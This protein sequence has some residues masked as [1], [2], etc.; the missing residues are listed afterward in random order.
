MTLDEIKDRIFELEKA[1]ETHCPATFGLE[2]AFLLEFVEHVANAGEGQIREMADTILSDY[3]PKYEQTEKEY[4]ICKDVMRQ[5]EEDALNGRLEFNQENGRKIF[6]GTNVRVVYDKRGVTISKLNLKTLRLTCPH[7]P[8]SPRPLC[9]S[10]PTI[11][12]R[13]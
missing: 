2:R 11:P 5:I 4:N 6:E 10:T 8:R 7:P 13:R 1:R 12:A 3:Q 9:A